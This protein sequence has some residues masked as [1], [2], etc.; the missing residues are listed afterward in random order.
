MSRKSLTTT[1][2]LLLLAGFGY[3][4]YPFIA[5]GSQMQDF[6][7]GLEIGATRQEIERAVLDRG[8]R[9]T[10][11]KEQ[12][13]FVHDTRSFG[14]FLCEVKLSDGSLASAIYIAND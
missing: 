10:F 13:G 8:Y 11:G 5:G 3:A 4:I 2:G 14:R 12:V 6:C 7:G 9:V 1:L